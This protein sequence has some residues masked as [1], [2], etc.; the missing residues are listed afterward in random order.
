[1][2]EFTSEIKPLEWPSL[3]GET[4]SL[5]RRV[6]FF[7]PVFG[8]ASII[9]RHIDDQLRARERQLLHT[10]DEYPSIAPLAFKCSALIKKHF[11]WINAY[12]LPNDPFDILFFDYTG[13]LVRIEAEIEIKKELNISQSL[14]LIDCANH[15]LK[16]F[17]VLKL[18]KAHKFEPEIHA[19]VDWAD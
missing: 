17:Q 8:Q 1:M 2:S 5:F 12:F 11:R 15:G 13:D 16:Y 14:V 9:K 18:M 19:D 4:L 6:T 7:F 3:D 10:W